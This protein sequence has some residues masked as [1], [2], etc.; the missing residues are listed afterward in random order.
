[1]DRVG[2]LRRRG[3][4]RVASTHGTECVVVPV[5]G[6]HDFSSAGTAFAAALPWL[7]G[8]LASPGAPAI[9]LPGAPGG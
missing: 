1:M 6:N 5:A 2:R 7:A 4:C 9:P 3:G 8:K